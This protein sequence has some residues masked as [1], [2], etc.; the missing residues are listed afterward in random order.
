M[1]VSELV[2]N[3]RVSNANNAYP[4]A[5]PPK[6]KIYEIL[7]GSQNLPQGS[8][9]GIIFA[10]HWNAGGINQLHIASEGV[11]VRSGYVTSLGTWSKL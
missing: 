10:Y 8:S 4:N 9:G 1:S 5:Y 2:C 3:E 11:W 7:N 6:M